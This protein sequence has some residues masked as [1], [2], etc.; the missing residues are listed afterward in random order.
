MGLLE[1]V[2]PGQREEKRNSELD[3]LLSET[4]LGGLLILQLCKVT[5]AH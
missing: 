4:L 5:F 3:F 2:R 1:K